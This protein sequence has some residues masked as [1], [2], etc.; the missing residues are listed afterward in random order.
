M[1]NPK[2]RKR[3]RMEEKTVLTEID[4]GERKK[5][6]I[7]SVS[8]KLLKNKP[9]VKAILCF[10]MLMV[11]VVVITGVSVSSLYSSRIVNLRLDNVGELVT[12]VGYFTNVEVIENNR[13]LWGITIPFTQSKYIFS[14]DGTIKAGINFEKIIW[15]V[16]EL[17]KSILIEM[18]DIEILSNEINPDSLE[19]YDESRNIFSPLKLDDMN[20]SFVE[21][22]KESQEKAV[23]NGL[24]DSAKA[25]AEV[26]VKGFMS[27]MFDPNVYAFEFIWG[28]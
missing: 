12:Q 18:P 2:R 9:R 19:V 13:E 4:F 25:N 16:D 7:G 21:L 20:Q 28:N 11:I 26:L 14:Y 24:F 3:D 6:G 5:K 23:A 10:A 22:K 1:E 17:S 15:Q 8:R 27:G